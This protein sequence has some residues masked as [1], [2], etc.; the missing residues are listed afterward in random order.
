MK[1]IKKIIGIFMLLIFFGVMIMPIIVTR[2]FVEAL[3]YIIVCVVLWGLFI[4][5][6]YLLFDD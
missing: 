6:S 3:I 1:L 5:G 2:G 4:G